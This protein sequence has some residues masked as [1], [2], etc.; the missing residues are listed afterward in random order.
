MT[1]RATTI[2]AIHAASLAQHFELAVELAQRADLLDEICIVCVKSTDEAP[3]HMIF[4]HIDTKVG[5]HTCEACSETYA[6]WITTHKLPNTPEKFEAWI[7][8]N[9]NEPLLVIS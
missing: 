2:A 4:T 8:T 9:S 7:R 6:R 1:D 5:V 3:S